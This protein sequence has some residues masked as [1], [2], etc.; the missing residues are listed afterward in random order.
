MHTVSQISLSSYIYNSLSDIHTVVVVRR[1]IEGS[2]LAIRH[3]A[4]YTYG[5]LWNVPAGSKIPVQGA[6]CN[7]AEKYHSRMLLPTWMVTILLL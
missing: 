1:H 4:K 2:R 7:I 5:S 6:R 3:S